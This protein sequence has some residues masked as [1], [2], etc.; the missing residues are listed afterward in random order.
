VITAGNCVQREPPSS[1]TC[2]RTPFASHTS[3]EGVCAGALRSPGIP[4]SVSKRKRMRRP[5][6]SIPDESPFFAV[7]EGTMENGMIPPK[8]GSAGPD[9]D[10]PPPSI[11]STWP[12]MK[13]AAGLVRNSM[14]P[15]TSAGVPSRPRAVRRAI[16]SRFSSESVAERSVSRKLG[17]IELTRMPR[18]PSSW[19]GCGPGPP[20][21]PSWPRRRRA[22]W[23]RGWLRCALRSLQCP[24]GCGPVRDQLD[25]A[26]A[27]IS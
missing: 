4:G 3:K 10:Q 26:P 6:S 1:S 21:R 15:S 14:A 27:H 25:I 23:S 7:H 9:V 24:A 19:A 13:A 20:R 16:R 18:E 11:V 2:R 17:A 8:N 12:V 5:E 22:R